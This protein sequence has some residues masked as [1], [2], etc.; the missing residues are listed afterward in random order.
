MNLQVNGDPRR[1]EPA[2]SPASLVSVIEAL[3]QDPRVV[4]V[5]H[6]GLIVPRSQW[7]AATVCDGDTLEI[8]TIVGGGS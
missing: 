3:G 2:S 7:E 8:V 4:V 5:E 6:N 1:L